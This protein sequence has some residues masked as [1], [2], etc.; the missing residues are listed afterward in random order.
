ML[1][2]RKRPKNGHCSLET[3]AEI[4]R[5][6]QGP[7]VFF[8]QK[9]D[10]I[11]AAKNETISSPNIIN[12]ISL[13]LIKMCC[14]LLSNL[15]QKRKR[16]QNSYKDFPLAASHAWGAPEEG[17]VQKVRSKSLVTKLFSLSA[18]YILALGAEG[19]MASARCYF[20]KN[21]PTKVC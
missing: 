8:C 6:A 11:S 3:D 16:H 15:L 1:V 20:P 13:M 4:T 5:R 21:K 7:P 12:Y 2:A 9:G 14:L 19:M 17:D 10:L 18:A